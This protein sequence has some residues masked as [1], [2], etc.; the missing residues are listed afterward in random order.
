M[1]TVTVPH[2]VSPN[3]W[4]DQN[5]YITLAFS[6]PHGGEKLIRLHSPG[7]KPTHSPIRRVESTPKIRVGIENSAMR[8][9]AWG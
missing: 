9:N 4:R 1:V 8:T 2:R 6:D 5:G 3:E 7:K